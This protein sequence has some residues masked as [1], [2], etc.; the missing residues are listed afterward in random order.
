MAADAWW[1]LF[2]GLML[3]GHDVGAEPLVVDLPRGG[4]VTG[5]MVEGGGTADG[6]TIRL[7]TPLFAD[8]LDLPAAD[9]PGS[10]TDAA[11]GDVGA[12]DLPGLPGRVG[13]L[14]ADGMRMY[15][16]LAACGDGRIGWQPLGASSP[17]PF[18]VSGAARIDYRG[19]EVV[20]GP[21]V[22]LVREGI[23]GGW[24]VVDV[25]A[26]GPA[27]RGGRIRAGDLVETCAEGAFGAPIDLSGAKAEA[28]KLVLVG[29]VGSLVRLGVRRDGRREEIGIVRDESGLEDLAGAAPR[30]VLD[31]AVAVRQSLVAAAPAGSATVHLR[32][33]ESFGCAVL[34]A[35]ERAVRLRLA[36]DQEAS[37][38]SDMVRAIELSAAG[39][40]PILKQK[41]ARLLTVPRS[42][43]SSPPT[44]VVR[45]SGGDYLRGR[46]LGIDPHTVRF[47]VLGEAKELARRDVAR[48]I[49][50]A[51][52][53]EPP[54][55]LLADLVPHG[56]L[57][58]VVVGGDG[59]RRAVAATG[60]AE[61]RLVGTSP[62]LGDTVLP[63]DMAAEVLVGSAIDDGPADKLPYAQ[64]VLTPPRPADAD[65]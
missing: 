60:M 1:A 26:A 13:L 30:D 25:H 33:G 5:V 12:G 58:M 4:R 46:L 17:V 56:G 16:C 28:V 34:G 53:D 39:V 14:T 45:M 20:G 37:V 6:T 24:K 2:A 52:A 63:L 51:A 44:H 21:G 36:K 9:P 50:L 40:K 18:A 62:S 38:P 8:P 57:P 23:T 64:W 11:A 55:S 10:A 59:R 27:A 65:R 48:I 7:R 15:G 22:V 61:G 31:R 47:D 42:Q 35:D 41:L 49:R 3:T 54:P 19:L 32:S 29:P 43:R